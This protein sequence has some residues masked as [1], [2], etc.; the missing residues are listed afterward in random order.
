[1]QDQDCPSG[2]TCDGC[3]CAALA[4]PTVIHDATLKDAADIELLKGIVE[5]ETNLRLYGSNLTSTAGL[6][7]VRTVGS[8]DLD[9]LSG[10]LTDPNAPNPFAGLSGL[11]VIRGN[12]QIAN[13]PISAIELNPELEVQG[14]VTVNYTSMTCA[15][16]HA[17]QQT[18]ASHGFTG[19]F[20]A[21]FNGSC[22]GACSQ[23]SCFPVP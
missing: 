1:V 22:Q 12:L 20:Q 17:L 7:G 4:V 11:A 23:G 15:T 8:L 2:Q 5:V 13:V 9:G 10:L 16:L 21:M 19:S 3:A 18:L 6:E 14:N